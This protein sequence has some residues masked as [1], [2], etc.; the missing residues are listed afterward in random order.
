MPNRAADRPVLHVRL[1]QED[2]WPPV[3]SEEVRGVARDDHEYVIAGVPS[4][5]RGLAV[6]GLVRVIHHGDENTLWVN[7]MVAPGGHSTIRVIVYSAG[8]PQNETVLSSGLE[9]LGCVVSLTGFAGL[10]AVDVPL[11]AGCGAVL[12]F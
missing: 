10:T 4:Y 12:Q 8:D 5:S 2:C 9:K 6:G 1:K 7:E 11:A 3:A